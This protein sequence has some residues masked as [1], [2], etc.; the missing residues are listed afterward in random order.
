MPRV[1]PSALLCV[2]ARFLRP[3]A[4]SSPTTRSCPPQTTSLDTILPSS[5]PPPYADFPEKDWAKTAL[6]GIVFAGAFCGMIAMGYIGDLLGRRVGMM[7][8]LS[9]VVL[10]S[11]GS[12]ASLWL[13][14]RLPTAS[15]AGDAETVYLA[16]TVLRFVLGFGV[17]RWVA[18][19]G[20]E[21]ASRWSA[22][23][24]LGATWCCTL[25][26]TLPISPSTRAASIP[27]LQRPQQRR[28]K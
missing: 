8:T 20:V 3:R 2:S 16:L 12:A 18:V 13:P 26:L 4:Y 10:G 22:A 9:L 1:A 11:L 6:K 21:A 25:P 23:A 15:T 14:H 27:W 17:V 24:L 28:V 19:W 7:M 5:A